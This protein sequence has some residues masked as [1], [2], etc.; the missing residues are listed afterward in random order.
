MT[1]SDRTHYQVIDA[2]PLAA[3]ADLKAA[4]VV[5]LEAA[6]IAGDSDE[7]AAVRR[8]WQVLSDP[9]QRKRYDEAIGVNH[10]GALVPVDVVEGEIL[11]DD[12]VEADE[13][14]VVD[15]EVGAS[16]QRPVHQIPDFLEQPTLGRRVAASLI[17]VVT[18][19]A[20]LFASGGIAYGALG[21]T[22][23]FYATLSALAAIWV[24][25]LFVV[26]T[27]RTGQTLGKRMT[28]VMTVDR[29]TGDLVSTGQLVRRYMFPFVLLVALPFLGEMGAFLALFFGLSYAMGKDQLSLADRLAKTIVVVAR[30]QPTRTGQDA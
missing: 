6:Q 5:A 12:G 13:A 11:D 20:V 18:T 25:A 4:Y 2:D 10:R 17:D 28:Y 8:A 7:S 9:I 30:Y 22:G 23:A 3:K 19:F 29:E 16:R 26:P 24:L 1:V 27:Y 14:E 21:D 15:G